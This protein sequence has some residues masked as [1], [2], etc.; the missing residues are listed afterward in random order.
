MIASPQDKATLH[1]YFHNPASGESVWEA[2]HAD[3]A[4][5]L[6]DVRAALKQEVDRTW[7]ATKIQSIVRSHQCR[8]Q[9]SAEKR[10]SRSVNPDDGDSESDLPIYSPHFLDS[11]SPLDLSR[12]DFMPEP[13]PVISF[14]P[15]FRR[16][17]VLFAIR[18]IIQGMFR[19]NKARCIAE[20]R[21][22]YRCLL[23]MAHC[24][25]WRVRVDWS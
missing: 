19:V 3:L 10:A 14:F 15:D 7:A 24:S 6:R 23:C 22:R 25:V 9:M 2:P 1:S 4:N 13:E 12:H 11:N 5:A 16:N 21:R 20:Q 17:L 18:R 8:R